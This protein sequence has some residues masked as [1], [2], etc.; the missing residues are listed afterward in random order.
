MI[1]NIDLV[2]AL[3][4]SCVVCGSSGIAIPIGLPRFISGII[5][6]IQILVPVIIILVGMV[7]FIKAIISGDE[8]VFKETTS[9]FIKKIIAGIF[10]FLIIAVVRLVFNMVGDEGK[11]SLSCV[12]CFLDSDGCIEQACPSR[13]ENIGGSTTTKKQH[14][15]EFS[16]SECP[17]YDNY[18]VEC[19]KVESTKKCRASEIKSNCEDYTASECPLP[20]NTSELGDYCI[21]VDFSSDVRLCMKDTSKKHCTDYLSENCPS[22][23]DYGNECVTEHDGAMHLCAKKG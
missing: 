18:N 23:D 10:I 21:V 6:L 22:Q 5:R 13:E 14:C 19:E 12:S 16:Y 3:T 4:G 9:S 11:T 17:D 1:L 2:F 20:P 8:K 15:S 7:D